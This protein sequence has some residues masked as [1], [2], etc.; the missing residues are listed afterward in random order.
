M[1]PLLLADAVPVAADEGLGF[2]PVLLIALLAAGF[3]FSNLLMTH[4]LGP[5]RMG[6]VKAMPYES[7]VDPVG[8]TKQPFVVQ[9]YL[10]ALLFL[11]FDVE[12]AFLYPWATIFRE[13]A[14]AKDVQVAGTLLGSMFLFIFILGFA[15]VYA[16]AKGVFDW[17]GRRPTRS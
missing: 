5:S 3:A 17:S 1:M 10:V 14:A 13:A 16:W 9:Y 2:V 15:F 12:L 4:L 7:G 6:E 11:L 8:D